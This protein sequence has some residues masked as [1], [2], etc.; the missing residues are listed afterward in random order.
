MITIRIDEDTLL[1]MLVDRVKSWTDDDDTIELF[2]QYY[3]HMVYSGCFDSADVDIMSVVDNDYIN[4]LTIV[5]EEE[6]KKE[7]AE[8]IEEQLKDDG[9]Y[10]EDCTEEEREEAR[11][12]YE[13]DTPTWEELEIG[14]HNLDFLSGYYI[15]A[16]TDNSIL[17][18]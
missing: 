7:R 5:T 16:K 8:Y 14:K 4:N 6:Y 1:E 18:S 9:F 12:E 13:K 2:E 3:D 17:M 10:D 15:E 11:K